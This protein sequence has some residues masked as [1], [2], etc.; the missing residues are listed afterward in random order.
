MKLWASLYLVVWLAF[1]EFVLVWAPVSGIAPLVYVHVLLGVVIFALAYSN[2][3]K[4]SRTDCPAR[5]KR[6]VK[7]TLGLAA[8]E[9]LL[10]ILLVVSKMGLLPELI[11]N[12]TGF[13][14]L[15]AAVAIVTQ[16]A[17]VATAHDMW[18]EKEFA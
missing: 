13:L 14:H 9:G 11:A 17:S 1:L 7:T 3:S 6:I 2:S 12:A 15:V 10:G 8:F 16:A 5:L 18:E 4:L